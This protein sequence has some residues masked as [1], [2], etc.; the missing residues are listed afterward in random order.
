[1]PPFSAPRNVSWPLVSLVVLIAAATWSLYAWRN[2]GEPAEVSLASGE[3]GTS[4]ERES[5]LEPEHPVSLRATRPTSPAP[6]SA[7]DDI[8]PA[9]DAAV[10]PSGSVNVNTPPAFAEPIEMELHKAAVPEVAPANELLTKAKSAMAVGNLIEARA[11][12]SAA[13][14]QEVAPESAARIRAE[15]T[16]LSQALLFSRATNTNDPL[17]SIHIVQPGDTIYVLAKEFGVTEELIMSISGVTEPNRLRVGDRL[18]VIRGPFSAVI[19][20]SDHRMDLFLGDQYVR[21]YRVGLGTNGGTPTGTWMVI[22]KLKNPDWTDPISNQYYLAEDP[23]NPIGERWVGLEG[24]SGEAVGRTGFGIHGTIDPASIGE[25]M[26]MGCIR[27]TAE[28]V[29]EVFDLLVE[30]K[31]QVTIN[32]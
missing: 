21:S 15:L 3:A 32:P 12:Y 8:A 31:S 26:S 11:Q 14:R 28:D 6:Q 30:Y 16:R 4:G 18:K 2:L 29:A 9:G 25:N 24:R 7:D 20:K 5:N 17:T 13:L 27:M 22:S 19:S 1:M 23:D 10:T